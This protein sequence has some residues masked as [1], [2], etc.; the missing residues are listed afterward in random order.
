[1]NRST[2]RISF[3]LKRYRIYI[4]RKMLAYFNNPPYIEFLYEEER[5]ILA[6]VGRT[7]KTPNSYAISKRFYTDKSVDCVISRKAFAEALRLRLGWEENELYKCEGSYSPEVGMVVFELTQ[8]KK[9]CPEA[10]S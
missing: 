4:H 7:E 9:F 10:D 3:D 6:I 1:M 8:A 5:K 2:A